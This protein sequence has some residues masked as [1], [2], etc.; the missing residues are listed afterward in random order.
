MKH[1]LPRLI[2]P[3][4]A[5]LFITVPVFSQTTIESLTLSGTYAISLPGTP[6]GGDID[7]TGQ[8]NLTSLDF[9][10]GAVTFNGTPVDFD[11]TEADFLSY[12]YDGLDRLLNSPGNPV[13]GT[14]TSNVTGPGINMTSQSSLN[15]I[16]LGPAFTESF[17]DIVV[18]STFDYTEIIDSWSSS[19]VPEL[20]GARVTV[21]GTNDVLNVDPINGLVDVTGSGTIFADPIVPTLSLWGLLILLTGIIGIAV[22]MLRRRRITA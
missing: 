10:P 11:G 2:I 14:G 4:F 12:T 6:V 18:P 1:L 21:S 3:A 13:P 7:F 22:L 8:L 9:A 19:V 5:L 16:D 15:S 17:F 20:N